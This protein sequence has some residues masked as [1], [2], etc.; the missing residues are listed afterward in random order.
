MS[1][2]EHC[3]TYSGV[4]VK[5]NR[6]CYIRSLEMMPEARRLAEYRR[7]QAEEGTKAAHTLRRLVIAEHERKAAHKTGFLRPKI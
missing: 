1:L 3:L 5:H 2:C 6:C 7:V 4:Y